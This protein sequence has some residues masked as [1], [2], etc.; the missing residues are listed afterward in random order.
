MLPY[1]STA[2]SIK[3]THTHTHTHIQ[4]SLPDSRNAVKEKR[5]VL[6]P[7]V[8]CSLYATHNYKNSV[9]WRGC[10]N[11]CWLRVY[12][13]D[14][15]LLMV[16]HNLLIT[17]IQA[18]NVLLATLGRQTKKLTRRDK[19]SKSKKC[20]TRNQ[21]MHNLADESHSD[22]VNYTI[23]QYTEQPIRSSSTLLNS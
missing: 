6:F 18:K 22:Y 12:S 17:K 10:V 23:K 2:L 11:L 16:L 3:H 8:S 7:A 5:S 14:H 15:M 13:L 21:A 20:K 1:H 9:C 4:S 19:R